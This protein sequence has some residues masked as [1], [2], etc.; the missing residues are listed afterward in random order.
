MRHWIAAIALVS[1]C[2]VQIGGLPTPGGSPGIKGST[3][4]GAPTTPIAS[5][6]PVPAAT[7]TPQPVPSAMALPAMG[8]YVLRIRARGGD[9]PYGDC[10][11]T[12]YRA[13]GSVTSGVGERKTEGKVDRA[14]VDAVAAE[15]AKADFTAIKAKKF[16]DV[17]PSAY[18][19]I[20]HVYNFTTAQ[21]DQE[22]SSC[23]YA[24]DDTHPLFAAVHKL[25]QAPTR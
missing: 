5:D 21:G 1:G 23:T 24:L 7:G 13:D 20:E 25:G 8:N 10:G 3:K 6:R 14:L 4:P 16:T 15:I 17:C 12:T 18:D 2:T 22:I 11:D 19:G 9:C